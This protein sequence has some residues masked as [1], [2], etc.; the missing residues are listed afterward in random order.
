MLLLNKNMEEK[1]KKYKKLIF[2]SEKSPLDSIPFHENSDVIER[3]CSKK[4]PV[5]LA[6]HEIKKAPKKIEIM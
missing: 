1:A 6:I 4:F 5:H 2:N 3:Y